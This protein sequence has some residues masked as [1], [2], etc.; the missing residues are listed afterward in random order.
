MNSLQAACRSLL[1]LP[2]PFL[3]VHPSVHHKTREYIHESRTFITV[4]NVVLQVDT[5]INLARS[6]ALNDLNKA[7]LRK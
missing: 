4:T 5:L 2:D 1:Q 3:Q 6:F 7:L